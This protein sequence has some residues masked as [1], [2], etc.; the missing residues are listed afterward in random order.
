LDV[1]KMRDMAKALGAHAAD[2]ARHRA[3]MPAP[4]PVTDREAIQ[5][6][7]NDTLAKAD[8]AFARGEISGAELA[9]LDAR[10]RNL[11]ASLQSVKVGL[12]TADRDAARKQVE[13]VM[14]Q[15]DA[16]FATGKIDSVRLAQIDWTVRRILETLAAAQ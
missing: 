9:E 2:L 15:A 12:S 3:S 11:L 5:Q 16:D 1:G 14:R 6:R 10:A 8:Q 4:R 13:A 7:V